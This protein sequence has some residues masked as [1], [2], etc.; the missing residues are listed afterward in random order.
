MFYWVIQHLAYLF[1]RFVGRLRII[2]TEHV[3]R[4]SGVILAANHSSYADPP[5]MGASTPRPIWFM[6]KIELLQTPFL[7]AFIKR[8]HAFPV[9]RGTADRQALRTAHEL[10]TGGEAV[11][12]FFEGGRSKDGRL[13][14]PAL[15]AGMIAL[16]ANVP[17][18]PVAIV[19]ADQLMPREG[20]L[21]FAR[22]TVIYGEPISFSHLEG[23]QSDRAALQE[24]GD[25]IAA[26]VA[27]LLRQHGAAERVPDGYPKRMNEV[28]AE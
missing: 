2:G 24:V 4:R 9:R 26:H 23:R 7:G 11:L 16:R 28:N 1:L 22:V 15:G 5:L 17:V 12:I 6:A 14:P 10:L 25:A 27:N 18:V 20:G 19:N 13:M 3:P 21:H 8:L